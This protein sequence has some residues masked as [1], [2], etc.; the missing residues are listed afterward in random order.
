MGINAPF[1]RLRYMTHKRS[2]PFDDIP[3]NAQQRAWEQA[4]QLDFF[5]EGV[6]ETMMP[7]WEFWGPSSTDDGWL[8]R[9]HAIAVNP[10]TPST[11]YIGH[12]KGGVWK[13]TDSGATW[14]NLTDNL[15]SQVVGC[16]A[17]DPVNPNIVYLGTGEEYFAGNTASGVGIWR[18][19]DAGATWTLYGNSTFGGRR[20]NEIVIDPSNGNHWIV[21]CDAGIYTT[22]DGGSSFVQRL[23]GTAS[24]LV[25]D[26]TTP[27]TL[28]CALGYPFG[29]TA[30]NGVYK[31][32]NGGTNWVLTSTGLPTGTAAGRI[33]LALCNSSPQTLYCVVADPSSYLVKGVYKTTNGATSW[34]ATTAPP[35]DPYGQGWYDLCIAV[36]PSNA[37]QVM[38]G[39]VR[40]NYSTNG[41]TSWTTTDPGHTDHHK[42]L[43]ANGAGRIYLGQD[44]G[45]Y[46]ETTIG[47]SWSKLNT[48]RGTMEYYDLDVHP[49]N[50]GILAAGAQDNATQVRNGTNSP[51]I[52]VIGGDGFRTAFN[53][54]TGSFFLGEIYYAS[55]YKVDTTTFGWSS[56]FSR[57]S[58]PANWNSPLVAD[59]QNT[60]RFYVGTN[61][62]Y[63]SDSSGSSGSWT[64]ISPNLTSSTGNTLTEIAPSPSNNNYI[65]VGANDGYVNVTTNG[66]TTW[67]N[68]TA[69]LPT[70]EIDGF[71]I[72]PT[73]PTTAFVCLSGYG[74][75]H[76][77][78][79][80]D[81]GATWTNYS[82]NLPD[83]PCSALVIN[84]LNTS[85]LIV[86]TDV[87]VFI[88][89]DGTTWS[90]LGTLPSTW[91]TGLQ[92][93]ATTGYL[94][95]C[96]YGRGCWRMPL[97]R[98]V[99]V[100]GGLT[101]SS[102]VSTAP[103][104]LVQ[105]IF[106]EPGSSVTS[107]TKVANIAPNGN[108]VLGGVENGKYDVVI[109]APQF[110]R[111]KVSL[112]ISNSNGTIIA[113]LINGDCNSDNTVDAS[114]YFILSD[115]Y[116]TTVYDAAY[117]ARADLNGDGSVDSS[118]YFIMSDAYDL[119]G[120]Q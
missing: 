98:Y 120:D 90:K 7:Q 86:G 100:A 27:Q 51:Y 13:S 40:V 111:K 4:Q 112:D 55:V 79:T 17:L 85:Q 12:A 81:A 108:F 47:G 105:F 66:G 15:S 60:N 72:D 49:T 67:T 48:G 99:T 28:Y 22:T 37:N 23:S 93:N 2:F 115:A 54:T 109:V 39:A 5:S 91:V 14:A 29:G 50:P 101:L 52:N 117:D 41:G 80:I 119:S 32:V 83:A 89:S 63:K 18:S 8:G 34:A 97:P 43:F 21:S 95:A 46:Y 44:S 113:T 73:T 118:D 65:Y 114:D 45:L 69:G 19:T 11:L 71:A 77:Y 78:K 104:R 36:N 20:I 70:R 42:L 94:T 88:T 74:S 103:T 106:R 116:D 38:I 31:S 24:A 30:S 53:R 82:G 87:G 107:F 10:T 102:L 25:M 64:A 56:V 84:P 61:K 1:E 62:V 6:R 16:L 110:L 35:A 33:E 3:R 9:I 76:V 68:R 58:D 26:P 75:G 96:T 57:G 59:R 92:A